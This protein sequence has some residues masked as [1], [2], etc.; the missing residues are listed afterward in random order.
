MTTQEKIIE[1]ITK[2]NLTD[3]EKNF[4]LNSFKEIP[5]LNNYEI[6]YNLLHDMQNIFHL[7]SN[8]ISEYVLIKNNLPLEDSANIQFIPIIEKHITKCSKCRKEFELFNQEFEE[9]NSFVGKTFEQNNEAKE[10][11][12]VTEKPNNIFNLFSTNYVYAAA[13]VIAFFTIS[14]FTISEII[15]PPYENLSELSELTNYSTTRGRVSQDFY[16]GIKALQGENYNMA[17]DFLRNDI[18]NNSDDET[19]FYTNYM[20][21][22][23]YFEKSESSFWGLFNSYNSTYLDSSIANFEITINKNN[24][25]LFSN[26]NYNSY[27][28]IGKAYL[29][30]SNFDEAKKH[31]QIV[32]DNKGS[33]LKEA[34]TLIEIIDS[35]Q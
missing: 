10:R 35:K 8:L 29:L 28:Y 34:Q 4:L 27:F 13:A 18:K 22:I 26:I 21:G 3:T 7:N 31:L 24:S 15:V 19:I 25:E 32:V 23:T 2:E 12:A 5:E 6:V 11:K 14:L 17:I 20:L 9:I 30:D 16:D 33:Y 1:L